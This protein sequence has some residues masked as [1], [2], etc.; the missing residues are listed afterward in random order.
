MNLI[1]LIITD[2]IIETDNSA[3]FPSTWLGKSQL[4]LYTDL[5]RVESYS[6]GNLVE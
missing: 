6:G 5:F 1:R 4:Y 3:N 2:F